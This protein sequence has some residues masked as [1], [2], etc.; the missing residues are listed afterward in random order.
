MISALILFRVFSRPLSC[1][2]ADA[3][4]PDAATTAPAA[5]TAR[6]APADRETD[7]DA[8]P[9]EAPPVSEAQRGRRSKKADKKE[10]AK[11]ALESQLAD[12]QTEEFA[13][14]VLLQ[15]R[16]TGHGRKREERMSGRVQENVFLQIGGEGG[17][18]GHT[19]KRREVGRG[20]EDDEEELTQV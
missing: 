18:G 20:K 16:G 19:N 13:F 7:L 15:V 10:A 8:A 14:D 17:R 6:R 1:A 9:D 3:R 5:V 11:A 12:A 4:S 2:A